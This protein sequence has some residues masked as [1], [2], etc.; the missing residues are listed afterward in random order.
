MKGQGN[1]MREV[2]GLLGE[3]KAGQMDDRLKEIYVDEGMIPYQRQRFADAI[4]KFKELYG[5]GEAEVYSAPGRSEVG[6]NHTDHQHGEVLAAS[7]NLDAIAVVRRTQEPVIELLSEGY[8]KIRV[9]LSDLEKREEEEGTSVGIIRGMAY[10]LKQ[11]GHTIGGFQAYV[12]SDVLNGAGMSSSAAFE[13]LVGTVISGLYNNMEISPVEI[14]QVAQYAENVFFGKPCGLMDQMACSVGGLI[15]IDFADP[16]NPIVEKVEV[17]FG[18]YQHS[19]CITDTKGSHADLT[20]DYAQIPQ[21]MKKV[22]S[23]FGKE[24]LREV[25]EKDFYKNIAKLQKEC[26]DRAVLRSLHFFE[27]DKR[28]EKEVNALKSGDFKGFLQTVKASGNSSFNYLQNVY[29]NK[30]VQNQGVSIG[31]AVS[32]S[33]LGSHG[34]SRVH[35]GGF[36][37]TIQAFVEDGFVENYREMLD[38]VF[39]EG[40]CHV[41][42]VRPFGGIRVW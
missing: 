34:V 38:S 16:K 6:G 42:K 8:E 37:G 1:T 5:A 29:T 36:A 35:G 28:V 27:E 3:L 7:I 23:F 30:D 18:A 24:F 33:I 40:A 9:D 21:E 15:H 26:G 39:G 4:C 20:D 12:T 25:D 14:A 17:D 11:N 2:E 19:L 22:A 32:E 41:L 31:L 13:T 10:G